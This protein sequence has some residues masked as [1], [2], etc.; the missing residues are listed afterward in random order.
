MHVAKGQRS[1]YPA[2]QVAILV[3]KNR[4]NGP[5]STVMQ[6]LLNIAASVAM[7]K[8]NQRINKLSKPVANVQLEL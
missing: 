5:H 4:A 1:W 8:A 3:Y 6:M 2:S 7:N